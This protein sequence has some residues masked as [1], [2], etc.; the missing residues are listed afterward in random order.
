M[1]LPMIVISPIPGQEERNADFLLESG[2][3]L[4]AIDAAALEYK[5][6]LLLEHPERLAAMR[7][8]MRAKARPDAAASVLR[9][10]AER[11]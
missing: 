8:C 4:K 7:E 11:L 5:V 1:Q 10:V 9:L 3:A 2:A 6:R